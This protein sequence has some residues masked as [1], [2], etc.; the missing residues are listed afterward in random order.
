M[1]KMVLILTLT[2]L[3]KVGLAQV[4]TVD[5][6]ANKIISTN[7]PDGRYLSTNGFIH[8]QIR[9]LKPMLQFDPNFSK[10]EFILWQAKVRNKIRDLMQF[11]VVAPQPSPKLISK[12]KR[13]GYTVEKWEIFPQ[14]GNVVPIL[15]LIPD[16]VSASKPAP[17]VLCYPG[18]YRSKEELAGEPELEPKYKVERSYDK[19]H[20]AKFYAEK[21]LV[22]IAIDNPGIA[23]LS[24]LERTAL[25]PSYERS[26]FSRYLMDMGWHYMGYSAFNGQ[27]VLNWLRKLD[28]VDAKRIALSGHS[29]GT[30]P[31]MMLAALNPDIKAVVFNDFLTNTIRRVTVSTKPNEKGFRPT[32]NGLIHCVPGLWRWADYVD[33]LASLA[34]MHLLITEGGVTMDLKTVQKAYAIAGAGKNYEYRYYKMYENARDRIGDESIPEGLDGNEF[35]RYANVDAPNHYFKADIAVPWLSSLLSNK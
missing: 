29:L 10:N 26:S 21:G 25:A 33:I 5:P 20:M 27:Q 28:F 7:R 6:E 4:S 35:F 12:V 32:Q 15:M 13:K 17:A 1:K 18:S 9:E 16:G 14:D 3:F 19:N 24:D 34:P 8:Q 31:V 11:P 2:G 22:A 23:E 30:E